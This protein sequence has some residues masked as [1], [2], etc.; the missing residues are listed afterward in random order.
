MIVGL[1]IILWDLLQ[2]I[3]ISQTSS[4]FVNQDANIDT[5]TFETVEIMI[6]IHIVQYTWKAH[7]FD[8]VAV[9]KPF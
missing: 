4:S 1:Y 6:N 2:I 8:A 7:L 5:N 3:Y 9:F